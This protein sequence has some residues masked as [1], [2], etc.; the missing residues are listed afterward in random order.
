MPVIDGIVQ[1]TSTQGV[2]LG[3][4]STGIGLSSLDLGTLC[5]STLINK[6][7]KYKPIRHSNV[8]YVTESDRA[9]AKQGMTVTK[10]TSPTTLRDNYAN[11][12]AYLQP[13]EGQSPQEW[14]RAFDF[15]Q[16]NNS[17]VPVV[18]H[19]YNR[20]AS[21]PIYGWLNKPQGTYYIGRGGVLAAVGM[22]PHGET[23]PYSVQLSDIIQGS[24]SFGDMYIG[25]MLFRGSSLPN[26]T[27]VGL[28][29]FSEEGSGVS[30]NIS[31]MEAQQNFQNVDIR[32][33]DSDFAYTNTNYYFMPVISFNASVT[34]DGGPTKYEA[35]VYA[36]PGCDIATMAIKPADDPSAQ[37]IALVINS[38]SFAYASGGYRVSI[39]AT[40]W[41][42]NTAVNNAYIYYDL[43]E[44]DSATGTP[45][46]TG[47]FYNYLTDGTIPVSPG[48]T[49]SF[50]YTRRA[51]VP[52]FVTIVLTDYYTH[53]VYATITMALDD[54]L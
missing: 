25:I 41:G 8:G 15:I 23:P 31:W 40:L 43:Y 21:A 32:F 16:V 51:S 19:G 54:E 33:S 9:T 47:D 44:G 6:W 20:N 12:W 35:G 11:E 26:S 17:G 53:Y 49:K 24:T 28:K 48:K 27:Y 36:C 2:S 1:V 5:K 37:N 46:A 22:L 34:L 38:S 45:V 50:S 42:V 13:R 30:R 7:A 39:G 52:S 10:Y 3:D 18:G 29:T 14:F 4:I